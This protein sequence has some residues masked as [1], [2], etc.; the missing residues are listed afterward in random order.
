MSLAWTRI[1]PSGLANSPVNPAG[2]KYYKN[3]ITELLKSGIVPAVTL[4]H[5][6]CYG[7][8]GKG[9]QEQ[10]GVRG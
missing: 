9:G 2:I 3:V 8:D 7:R 5:C 1:V 10:E 4:F 6:E